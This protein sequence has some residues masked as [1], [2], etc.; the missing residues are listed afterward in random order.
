VVG[1]LT[2]YHLLRPRRKR[3]VLVDHNETAQSVPGLEEAEIVEIIDHHRV[4]DIQTNNPI[5]VRNEPVG[6]T[7]TIIAGMFQDKGL[8]PSEKLAGL[9]AA[10]ILSDT[11]MFKSPTCTVRDI[12]TAERMARYANISLNELGKI[13]FSASFEG[14]T[15]KELLFTDYKEF[16]IAG[17]DLAVAQITCVDSSSILERK[18]EFLTEMRLVAEK[19]QV[20][21]VILMLTDVLLEGSQILYVG[22]DEIISQAFHATPKDNSV[23]LPQVMSRKKQIIPSLSALWG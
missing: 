20:A 18:E 15:I 7:N 23:F 16:H 13:I 22:D 3:V 2:R 17:H 12:R 5:F 9:I 4:A 6:S 1:V 19:K 14:K 21:M 11:V 8:I 10:A